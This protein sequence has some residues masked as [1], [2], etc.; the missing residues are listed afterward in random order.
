MKTKLSIF[1]LSAFL[2]TSLINAYAQPS[3][4]EDRSEL[5]ARGEY[6]VNFGG[7]NDCHTPKIMTPHG[8]ELDPDKLL[9]GHQSS[10]KLPPVPTQIIGPNSWGAIT[11]HDLT[12][13]VGPW[14]IS[15]SANLTP[16][17]ETGLGSWT[18]EI[19]IQSMRTGKH[20]GVGRDILP[21][22]PWFSLNAL[23]D[24]DLEAIFTYLQSVKAINN[25][26]PQPIP[27]QTS[28]AK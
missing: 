22:M 5:V 2:T 6:L 25:P 10:S 15:F 28:G 16:D 7:C 8:P 3:D 1:I 27:P 20:M 19:F 21:P 11:N 4:K 23:S 12:A 18:S 24:K 17:K 9:S 13:W 14:G 26:V